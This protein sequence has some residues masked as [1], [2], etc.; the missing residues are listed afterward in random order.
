MI[1]AVNVVGQMVGG[2]LG[3][4]QTMAVV[5]IESGRV[6]SWQEYEVRWDL[7]HDQ[8]ALGHTGGPGAV[9]HGSH[10]ARIVSFLRDHAVEVVVT[11]HAGPPMAHTLDLK[12][13]R[14]VTDV[15]GD[16]RT[17]AVTA[18]AGDN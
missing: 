12:G 17:A 5:D 4:A 6:I 7:S 14:L 13:V 2:G 11:G 3:R 1:V 9:S 10:H 16:A 15:V 18:V 8:I